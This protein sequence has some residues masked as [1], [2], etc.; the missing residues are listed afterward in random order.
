MNVRLSPRRSVSGCINPQ[1][2]LRQPSLLQLILFAATLFFGTSIVHAQ[3]AF[4][5]TLKPIAWGQ[6]HYLDDAG[7]TSSETF[8]LKRMRAGVQANV[9]PRVGFHFQVEAM[10]SGNNL[11]ATLIQGW[12]DY[13]LHDALN[14]RVGQFKYPFGLEV[15]ATG[16]PVWKFV[17]PSYASGGIA[18]KLGQEGG[19]Y[20]D[21]GLQLAGEVNLGKPFVLGYQLMGMNGNGINTVDTDGMKDIVGR[22]Y[23]QLPNGIRAG[24]SYYAGHT[25]EETSRWNEEALGF[26]AHVRHQIWGRALEIQGEYMQGRY[27]LAEGRVKSQGYYLYAAYTL[28]QAIETGLRYD[29][30]SPN[31][32]TQHHRVTA[33]L[34]YYLAAK[35]RINVNYEIRHDDGASS[36]GNLVV[37][38]FQFGL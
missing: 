9:S 19:A 7:L 1:R 26:H 2:P 8:M 14:I 22:T 5:P 21:L 29:T 34:G 35:Q 37:V 30:F 20:R 12:V 32:E 16:P 3:E 15:S 27:R 18:K 24:V 11:D 25:G 23:I 13:R 33:M 38:Q 10:G 28:S 4:N 6:I 17:H 36:I 31:A